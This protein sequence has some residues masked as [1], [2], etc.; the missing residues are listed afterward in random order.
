MSKTTFDAKSRVWRGA[1][2]PSIFNSNVSLG[3]LVLK[4]LQSTPDAVTQV[5][6]DTGSEVTCFEMYQRT[7]KIASYLMEKG[8]KKGDVAGNIAGNSE[9]IAAVAFACLTLG[10]PINS[11]APKMDESEITH[12][13]GNTK[14]KLIFADVQNVK[15]VQATIAEIPLNCVIF[16]VDAKVDGYKF[17]GDIANRDYNVNEFA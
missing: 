11:L 1:E 16:T 12:M 5:S 2:V 3:Y 4:V 13:F 6:A 9:H 17:I 7:V 8:F 14:P 10:L 15:K